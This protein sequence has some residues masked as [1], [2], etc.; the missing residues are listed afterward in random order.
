MRV[1]TDEVMKNGNR[2]A[3]TALRE[4]VT[5]TEDGCDRFVVISVD[6]YARLKR[7]DRRAIRVEDLTDEEAALIAAAEVPAEYGYL[8]ALLDDDV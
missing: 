3:D 8:D 5:V 7:R 6:E 2:V 1:A 4:P